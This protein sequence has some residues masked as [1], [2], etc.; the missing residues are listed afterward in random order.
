MRLL[1]V[2]ILFVGF[3]SACS[4]PDP[5]AEAVVQA[6]FEALVQGN[7]EA[8]YSHFREAALEQ[9]VHTSRYS[10]P[11]V[12]GVFGFPMKELFGQ[13]IVASRRRP[14]EAAV[15]VTMTVPDVRAI[16]AL[17]E[18]DAAYTAAMQRLRERLDV[19]KEAQDPGYDSLYVV[20]ERMFEEK[21]RAVC[22]EDLNRC[23]T[24]FNR[25]YEL[26][27]DGETWKIVHH[28]LAVAD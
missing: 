20:A 11:Y 26:E 16:V 2:C 28:P 27:K 13:R 1:L 3:L 10:D 19:L 15:V 22:R 24:T 12:G 25:T 7:A 21:I 4:Q 23:R 17:L 5:Q 6:Q 9:F 14:S 18:Q 8:F